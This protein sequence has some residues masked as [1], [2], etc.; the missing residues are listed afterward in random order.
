MQAREFNGAQKGRD[1]DPHAA[2][3][4]SRRI[5][6]HRRITASSSTITKKAIAHPTVMT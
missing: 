2:S 6:H 3:M 1:H 5:E 4:R